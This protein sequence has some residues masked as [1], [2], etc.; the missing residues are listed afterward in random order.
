MIHNYIPYIIPSYVS[1]DVWKLKARPVTDRDRA[2]FQF[3]DSRCQPLLSLTLSVLH[4]LSVYTFAIY[5][6]YILISS[7][8]FFLKKFIPTLPQSTSV[9][10]GVPTYLLYIILLYIPWHS[11]TRTAALHCASPNA[12]TYSILPLQCRCLIIHYE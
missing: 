11:Y 4:T 8:I 10:L 1:N 12:P 2:G 3:R 7:L 9:A 5:I 6:S